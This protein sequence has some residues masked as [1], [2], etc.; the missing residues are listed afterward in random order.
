MAAGD[1]TIYFGNIRKAGFVLA[2]GAGLN[3]DFTGTVDSMQFSNGGAFDSPSAAVHRRFGWSWKTKQVEDLQFLFNYRQGLYGTGLLYWI[4]PY[5]SYYNSLPPHWAAPFL[6]ASGWPSHIGAG[7]IPD[8][9]AA[10]SLLNNQPI[11]SAK[12]TLSTPINTVPDRALVLLIPPT[13]QINI[14]FSFSVINGA[15]I[16]IQPINI[17][18]TLAA[19]QDFTALS[20]SGT[21]RMN[22]SFSGAT[23]SAI[24]VYLTSTVSGTSYVTMDS[25]DAYY[26]T[27]GVTP[28]LTGNHM[29][30]RGHTGMKFASDP[31]MAYE[32]FDENGAYPRRYVSAA[33]TLEEVGGWL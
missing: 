6:S 26:T 31:T 32:F 22:K 30:G 7:N 10:T 5:A 20:A 9:V 16:R 19:T 24:K 15:V 3:A 29:E 18:G 13:M 2:P 4:D 11:Y 28:V 17:D 25:G 21:T 23:Y 1:P 33:V 8:I 27:L 14:G 12:Y